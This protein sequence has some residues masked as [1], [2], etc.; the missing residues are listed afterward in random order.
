[1]GAPEASP[2]ENRET[3]GDEDYI[4]APSEFDLAEELGSSMPIR[5]ED[6]IPDDGKEL[7]PLEMVEKRIPEKTR[8][9]MEELFRAKLSKVQ[10]VNPKKIK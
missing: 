2:F 9:L 7:P 6:I 3:E 1:M 10:R 8:V 5:D 4:D